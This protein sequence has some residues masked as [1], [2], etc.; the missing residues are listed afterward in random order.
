MIIGRMTKRVDLQYPKPIA[1]GRGGRKIDWKN[2]GRIWAEIK[3]PIVSVLE[4]SGAVSSILTSEMSIR[5]RRDISRGWRVLCEGKTYDVIHT[6]DI[7][8]DATILVCKEVIK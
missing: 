3:K 1:D 2:G 5:Q 7:N 8:R 6:Y 4:Q